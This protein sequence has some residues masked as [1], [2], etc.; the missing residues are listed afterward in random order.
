VTSPALICHAIVTRASGSPPPGGASISL[1]NAPMPL[2]VRDLSLYRALNQRATASPFG[3]GVVTGLW[4]LTYH[5]NVT[6]LPMTLE[7]NETMK[8]GRSGAHCRS[9]T[10]LTAIRQ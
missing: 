3:S 2:Q 6:H 7:S 4:P 5:P 1:P 10:R 9:M 8:P